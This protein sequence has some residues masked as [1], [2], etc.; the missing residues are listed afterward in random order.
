MAKSGIKT[1]LLQNFVKKFVPVVLLR[2]IR[3]SHYHD[4]SY[5][6]SN[7]TLLHPLPRSIL[8]FNTI[9]LQQ[10]R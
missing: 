10:K 5:N 6:G 8:C 2:C 9:V 7:S 1:V 3:I 4:V